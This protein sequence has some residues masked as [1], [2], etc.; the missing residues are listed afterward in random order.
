M[1]DF[2]ITGLGFNGLTGRPTGIG[3]GIWKLNDDGE[4]ERVDAGDSEEVQETT[5]EAQETEEEEEEDKYTSD[6]QEERDKNTEKTEIESDRSSL[7]KIYDQTKNDIFSFIPKGKTEQ[8]DEIR[9]KQEELTA[10]LEDIDSVTNTDNRAKKADI[11]SAKNLAENIKN[12]AD[13]YSAKDSDDTETH[14]AIKDINDAN[15]ENSNQ[16]KDLNYY[17]NNIKETLDENEV[18]EEDNIGADVE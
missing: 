13:G 17:I 11:S 8:G 2:T 12:L 4:W 18:D 5:N 14:D 9:K 3:S 16:S 10:E 6:V 1:S 15:N 7:Q